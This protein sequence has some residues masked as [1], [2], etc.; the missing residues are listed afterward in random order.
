MCAACV[1]VEGGTYLISANN[2]LNFIY[3]NDLNHIYA[4]LAIALAVPIAVAT[5]ERSFSKLKLIKI[6]TDRR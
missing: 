2:M 6:L 3:M 5:A 1:C 4:N